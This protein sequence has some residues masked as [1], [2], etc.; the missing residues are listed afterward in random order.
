MAGNAVRVDWSVAAEAHVQV[1]VIP[2]A[3][4]KLL[5]ADE[6][7]LAND[8]IDL[9]LRYEEAQRRYSALLALQAEVGPNGIRASVPGDLSERGWT[10]EAVRRELSSLAGP[11]S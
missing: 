11:P 9:G 7:P 1:E 6:R 5:V 10:T 8:L 4:D 3:I 2:R